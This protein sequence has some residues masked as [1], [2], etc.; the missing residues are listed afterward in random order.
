MLVF[1]QTV[2]EVSPEDNGSCVFGADCI[3]MTEQ[4]AFGIGV[5][6]HH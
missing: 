1:A 3:G 5:I 4:A 6:N 2:I